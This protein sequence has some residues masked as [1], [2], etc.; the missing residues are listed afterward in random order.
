MLKE[1]V[2]R[3]SSL[4]TRRF[5]DQGF[6]FI[7]L[8]ATGLSH[9]NDRV[10]EL[11]VVHLDPGGAP[12]R[13]VMETLVNPEGEVRG[14]RI[15]GIESWD[16]VDAPRFSDVVQAF[17]EATRDR[18]LV[19]HNADYDL[20]ML[21]AELTRSGCFLDRPPHLC[22]LKLC[23]LLVDAPSHRLDAMAE[24]FAVRQEGAHR[25][26]IDALVGAAIFQALLALLAE[27]EVDTAKALIAYVRAQSRTM[28]NL[29]SWSKPFWRF[30]EGGPRARL[31]TRGGLV[32]SRSSAAIR[33]YHEEVAHLLDLDGGLELE[34]ARAAG[35]PLDDEQRRF[36]HAKVFGEALDN[37]YGDERLDAAA[38]Q[39]LFEAHTRLASLG[40]APGQALEAEREPAPPSETEVYAL[41]TGENRWITD[42]EVDELTVELR[43]GTRSIRA[44]TPTVDTTALLLSPAGRVRSDADFIFYNQPGDATD[45]VRLRERE[46]Q[47]ILQVDLHALDPSVHRILLSASL[48]H[49]DPEQT[50]D[51]FEEVAITLSD[52]ER[53]RL[54]YAVP[55]HELAGLRAIISCE[56]YRAGDGWKMRAV[57]Q[58]FERGLVALATA[59]GVDVEG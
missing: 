36:V 38:A 26:A 31:K 34:G 40:W 8:E 43:V 57:G 20:R 32:P 11:A 42:A 23:R 51:G 53:P 35:E 30:P 46:G 7:D 22:T 12:P 28:S 45:P 55:G 56:L 44:R 39:R 2:P 52:D 14:T 47:F 1:R 17:A 49:D 25:A 13:L 29:G 54:I 37:A 9:R 27:L 33:K 15:H 5:S 6:A 21:G 10:L 16:V 48:E 50:F 58:G 41:Q 4:S 59:H 24:H 19:A 3:N 18:V